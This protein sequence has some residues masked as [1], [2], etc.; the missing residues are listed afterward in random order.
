MLGATIQIVTHGGSTPVAPDT[1]AAAP[2]DGLTI[3]FSNLSRDLSGY[4][5]NAPNISYSLVK[6]SYIGS[7]AQAGEGLFSCAGSPYQTFKQLIQAKTQVTVIGTTSSTFVS[8]L[9]LLAAYKIPY[10]VISGY[11]ATSDPGLRA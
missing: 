3:G 2:A 4:F 9:L 10:R 8:N 11:T 1:I 5:L 7:F 6:Q